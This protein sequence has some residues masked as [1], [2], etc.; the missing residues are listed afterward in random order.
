MTTNFEAIGTQWQ[1]DLYDKSDQH[2]TSCLKAVADLIEEFDRTFSRFRPDSTVT[3]IATH[4]GTYDLGPDAPALLALYD[5][6]YEVTDGAVTPLIGQV[7]SD[8]GYDATYSL[9]ERTLTAPKPWHQAVQVEGTKI[10]VTQSVLLDFGAAGKGYL[11]DLVAGLIAKYGY[12]AFTVN[13]G[14]D[15]AHVGQT[16][17]QVGLEHPA[18]S[19]AVIGT[20]MLDNRSLCGSATNRRRW[21]RFHHVIDP[22]SLNSPDH[23]SCVWVIA[24]DTM[25][26][27]G[28]TT[29]L[30]FTPPQ[31]LA[32]YFNFEYVL[33]DRLMHSQI[34]AGWPGKLFTLSTPSN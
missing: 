6:L 31:Q 24:A 4:P 28:L 30:F 1:I 11:V 18:D 19:S 10:T 13:A 5:K 14:G 9:R 8:A 25:T 23:V 29:A 33:V 15:I 7:L 22:R 3:Q 34:S 16:P 12:T 21:G 17:L 27:D 20:A 26:A 2:G 32:K